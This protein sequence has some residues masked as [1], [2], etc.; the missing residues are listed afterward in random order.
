MIAHGPYKTPAGFTLA[1][2]LVV[3]I[4]LGIAAT[5]MIPM[6]GNTHDL[7]ASSAVRRIA[8]SLLYAQTAAITGQVPCQVVFDTAA[9]SY[10]LQDENGVPLSDTMTVA[11]NYSIDF[12]SDSRMR[13]VSIATA[14]FDGSNTVWFDPL[15]APYGGSISDSPPPLNNGTINVTAGEKTMTV[16][17]E[18]VTGRINI[19]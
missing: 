17:V 7:Q 19:N 18:P 1:E 9:N 4:I 6:I 5:I 15:G 2:V 10:E 8:S 11:G 3:L 12:G 16:T 13:A 14:D